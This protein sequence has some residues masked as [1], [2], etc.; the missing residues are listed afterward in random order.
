ML[1][2]ELLSTSARDTGGSLGYQVAGLSAGIAP[3]AFAGVMAGGGGT[4]VVSII[5]AV[6][7]LVSV[8]CIVALR[9]TATTDLTADP[10]VAASVVRG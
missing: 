4:F 5:V 10:E 8:G 2:P 1:Y 3:L 6:W 7:Y 9:E